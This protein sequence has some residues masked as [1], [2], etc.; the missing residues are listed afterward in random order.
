MNAFEG[1]Y[2]NLCLTVVQQFYFTSKWSTKS[3]SS[4]NYFVWD[5]TLIYQ[6]QCVSDLTAATTD[7]HIF[8]SPPLLFTH[9]HSLFSPSALLLLI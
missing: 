5:K 2:L 1:S 8:V 3:T 7:S 4:H 6:K 9:R